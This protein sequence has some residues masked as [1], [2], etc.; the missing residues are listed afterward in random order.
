MVDRRRW[1]HSLAVE[2][3]EIGGFKRDAQTKAPLL[4][5]PLRFF[6]YS[7]GAD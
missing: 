7:I 4:L 6:P 2:T 1:R 5:L 3:I